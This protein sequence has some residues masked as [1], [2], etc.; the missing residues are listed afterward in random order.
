MAAFNSPDADLQKIAT[1][2]ADTAYLFSGCLE[3]VN[4]NEMASKIMISFLDEVHSQRTKAAMDKL[5]DNS[6]EGDLDKPI[7][8]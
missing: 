7:P 6:Y 2:L 8:F 4:P 1:T 5:I 3:G